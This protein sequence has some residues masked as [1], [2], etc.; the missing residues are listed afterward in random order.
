MI[1]LLYFKIN[2]FDQFHKLNFSTG[3]TFN[4]TW[5]PHKKHKSTQFEWQKKSV[6]FYR[7]DSGIR[8]QTGW[9][10]SVKK[11]QITLAFKKSSLYPACL[12]W[13]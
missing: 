10:K 7:G 2:Y 12:S 9:Y 11:K 13:C 6:M 8:W 4:S 1:G 5:N 3:I